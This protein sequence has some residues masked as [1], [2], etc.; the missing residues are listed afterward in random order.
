MTFKKKLSIFIPVLIIC[1]FFLSV[2]SK[3]KNAEGT[4]S[5]YFMEGKV[6]FEEYAWHSNDAGFLLHASGRM[7]KPIPLEI[8]EL[9]LSL[10]KNFIPL[11][12]Y[13]K[14]SVSGVAQ[15]IIS[16]ISDGYVQN[17]ISVSGQKRESEAKIRRDAF[18]LPNAIFSPYVVLVQKFRCQLVE[19]MELSAYVIPQLEMPFTLE[20]RET[21]PC[22]L[23]MNMG[24]IRI[25]IET[26]S[27]GSLKSII[28][29]S[30]KLKVIHNPS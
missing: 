25:E 14:G 28:I 10:N 12:F 24:G 20:P 15:E 16:T 27:E 8:N 6:G 18:I 2:Y 13:F 19:K 11:E 21:D 5:V 23:I 22:A 4:L 3:G 17:I 26:D 7:T 30:Q 29:P 9:R 1:L